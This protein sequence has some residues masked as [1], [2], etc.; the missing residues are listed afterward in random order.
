[1]WY[2]CR[3]EKNNNP[4]LLLKAAGL[5]LCLPEL[6]R[7]LQWKWKKLFPLKLPQTEGSQAGSV[8]EIS[9]LELLGGGQSYAV[10]GA[11]VR[12][13]NP[14][15]IAITLG[16]QPNANTVLCPFCSLR[17]SVWQEGNIPQHLTLS[18]LF[19]RP[20]R[21]KPDQKGKFAFCFYLL[22]AIYST[23]WKLHSCVILP[24][25]R[26][27]RFSISFFKICHK[28]ALVVCLWVVFLLLCSFLDAH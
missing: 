20:L 19:L 26:T 11:L 14:E 10:G 3:K 17:A 25:S 21:C 5:D 24:A 2:H 16:S 13:I 23:F 18:G 28:L 27:T 12:L 22:Y 8:S 6:Q 4:S 15:S 7:F 1:M 9:S